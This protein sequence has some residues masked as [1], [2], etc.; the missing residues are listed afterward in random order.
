MT[1][2]IASFDV[3][4]VG[5]GAIGTSVAFHL[6]DRGVRCLLLERET[7]ASGSTGRAAGGIRAQ[8]ADEL[9]VRIMQRS[10]TAFARFED[11]VGD[12]I[13]FRRCGYLFLID[14]ARDLE[15]FGR[16]I[17]RQRR[18]G[19]PSRLL[20]PDEVADLLPGCDS[21]GL[22]GAAYC[23]EDG[24]ATPESVAQ[25]YARAAAARGAAVWQG[26]ALRGIDVTGGRITGVD[27]TRGRV[28][29]DTVVCAAGTGS[30]AVAGL[31][32]IALPVR[33]ERHWLFWAPHGRAE[34]SSL[35]FTI[36]FGSGFH[37][38]DEGSGLIFG[39]RGGDL[40][41]VAAAAVRRLPSMASVEVAG[42]WWGDYDLSPDHNGIVGEA[43]GPGRFFYATG[44]SGHGFMQ[45]PAVGEHLAQRICGEP[46]ALDLSALDVDRFASAAARPE[47]LIF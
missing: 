42:G 47:P 20:A 17:Q 4:V 18:L 25:G 43:P 23:A 32:D 29:T 37:V 11:E 44:F 40:A 38:H 22:V 46:V 26:C 3:V 8:F 12:A 10:L 33:A 31:A 34:V 15:T 28:R 41:E 19:V 21:D 24:R 45:S 7:V 27:T 36:D 2:S 16:S 14:D 1:S 35:P 39:G 13:G 5:A 30:P 9:N 6:A